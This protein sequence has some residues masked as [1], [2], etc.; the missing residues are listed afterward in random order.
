ML[1]D[2][3]DLLPNSPDRYSGHGFSTRDAFDIE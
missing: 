1:T 2:G 3:G